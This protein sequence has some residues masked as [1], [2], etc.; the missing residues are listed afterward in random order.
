MPTVAV[1][2]AAARPATSHNSGVM[3]L[4]GGLVL[5]LLVAASLTLLR[6]ASR[7]QREIMGSAG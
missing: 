2:H 4:V 3:L 5:L 1:T 7:L 6:L